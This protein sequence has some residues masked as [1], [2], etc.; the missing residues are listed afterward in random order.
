MEILRAAQPYPQP[1]NPELWGA[2]GFFAANCAALRFRLQRSPYRTHANWVAVNRLLPDAFFPLQ[3]DKQQ[4]QQQQAQQSGSGGVR[5]DPIGQQIARELGSSIRAR[6][7]V[8]GGKKR[9][10]EEKS[11]IFAGYKLQVEEVLSTSASFLCQPS[12][13]DTELGGVSSIA[14]TAVK[15]AAAEHV[16]AAAIQGLASTDAGDSRTVKVEVPSSRLV[17]LFC[18]PGSSAGALLL[19]RAEDTDREAAVG[20]PGASS[21]IWQA[22]T[23]LSLVFDEVW[24]DGLLLALLADSQ[25][26]STDGASSSQLLFA[27][28][29][30]PLPLPGIPAEAPPSASAAVT[31]ATTTQATPAIWH[32]KLRLDNSNGLMVPPMNIWEWGVAWW[33]SVSSQR[34]LETVSRMRL[35]YGRRAPAARALPVSSTGAATTGAAD[36]EWFFLDSLTSVDLAPPGQ[37]DRGHTQ[38]QP[39]SPRYCGFSK[40]GFAVSSLITDYREVRLRSCMCPAPYSLI[41]FR[42]CPEFAGLIFWLVA[43]G[44]SECT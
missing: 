30:S 6:C 24:P 4:S 1:L 36:Q 9:N 39:V 33:P 16:E 26:A 12:L 13:I 37:G 35:F 19:S 41:P 8:N 7:D 27:K 43:R 28:H 14:A 3:R 11:Y 17:E 2:R 31:T 10:C 29:F 22:A 40:I 44:V 18:R 42:I 5:G 38:Q 25:A 15:A 23:A 21:S 20:P 34:L 32:F